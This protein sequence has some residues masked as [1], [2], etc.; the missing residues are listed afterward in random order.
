MSDV[1]FYV[2]AGLALLIAVLLYFIL[3]KLFVI[4]Q[5]IAMVDRSVLSLSSLETAFM[6]ANEQMQTRI[7][8][9]T[10][11]AHNTNQTLE[12]IAEPIREQKRRAEYARHGL[13]YDLDG[14]GNHD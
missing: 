1:Q 7:Y 9:L 5:S 2:L 11:A 8:S 12:E 4:H 13:S 3:A 10:T 6:D 14:P